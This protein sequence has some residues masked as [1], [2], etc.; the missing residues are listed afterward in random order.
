ML[1]PGN[2]WAQFADIGELLI[3]PSIQP[4]SKSAVWQWSTYFRQFQE[5]RDTP[6]PDAED[7]RALM[8]E[9]GFVDIQLIE[10]ILDLGCYTRGSNFY[11]MVNFLLTEDPISRRAGII[12]RYSMGSLWPAVGAKVVPIDDPVEKTAFIE[13]AINELCSGRAPVAMK[14]YSLVKLRR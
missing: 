5:V 7:Q 2:G 6:T 12:A 13:C 9:I 8:K 4:P 3:D 1:K 11:R 10:K 14:K